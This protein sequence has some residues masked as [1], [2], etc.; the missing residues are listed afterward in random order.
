MPTG[1]LKLSLTYLQATS[2]PI[3]RRIC[4]TRRG[5][6]W[7][8]AGL[9]MCAFIFFQGEVQVGR[10]ARVPRTH[11]QASRYDFRSLWARTALPVHRR[12]VSG[13][14]EH[15]L[16]RNSHRALEAGPHAGNRGTLRQDSAGHDR[17]PRQHWADTRHA[18]ARPSLEGHTRGIITSQALVILGSRVHAIFGRTTRI[19]QVAASRGSERTGGRHEFARCAAFHSAGPVSADRGGC[20]NR[21]YCC[22]EP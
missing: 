2:R 18:S 6:I 15:P 16:V 19:C 5:S 12:G 14:G 13:C 20:T 7:N 9:L 8:S 17:L 22:A 3:C 1:W 10:I 11:R 4:G 21:G